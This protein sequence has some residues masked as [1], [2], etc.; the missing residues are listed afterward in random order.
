MN[1]YL[2]HPTRS[3][4]PIAMAQQPTMNYLKKKNKNQQVK[5]TPIENS[6]LFPS[7]SRLSGAIFF[8]YLQA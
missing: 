6:A 4:V 8:L 5:S 7:F 3:T 2:P 1:S